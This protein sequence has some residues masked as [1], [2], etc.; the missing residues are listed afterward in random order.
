M[1]RLLA[2]LSGETIGR[3]TNHVTIQSTEPVTDASR[4]LVEMSRLRARARR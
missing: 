2:A 3:Q 4:M 1:G